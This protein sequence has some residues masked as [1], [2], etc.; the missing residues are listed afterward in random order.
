MS[1]FESQAPPEDDGADLSRPL[2][3]RMRPRTLDEYVGQ[4]HLLGEKKPLRLQIERDQLGSLIF[5]G[6]PGVGKTTLARQYTGA[7]SNAEAGPTVGGV[8]YKKEN[9]LLTGESFPLHIW[10]TAGEE[11]SRSIASM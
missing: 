1:L 5:W 9:Q 4:Q 3:E 11:K 7:G 8:Y 2:A 10:D 6:P